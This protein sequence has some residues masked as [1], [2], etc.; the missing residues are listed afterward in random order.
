MLIVN[1]KFSNMQAL[2]DAIAA[3]DLVTAQAI[4]DD[5]KTYD[6][7]EKIV[8]GETKPFL[9]FKNQPVPKPIAV[10]DEALFK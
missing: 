6:A 9:G 8:K 7:Y 3:M 4:E 5:D 1:E 10:L 2:K